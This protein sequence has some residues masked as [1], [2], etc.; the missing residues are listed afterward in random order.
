MF[1]LDNYLQNNNWRIV[2]IQKIES[3][4]GQYYSYDD[5]SLSEYTKILLN[6]TVQKG[7]YKHQKEAI[8]R[9]LNGNNVCLSTGTASGKSLVFYVAGIEKLIEQHDTRILAIYPLKALGKEQE[10]RWI[11]ALN[12]AKINAHV[13]RLDGQ[14]PVNSRSTI[15]KDKSIL[16]S[17]PDI[18][19]AWLMPN[20][21]DRSVSTFLRNLSL[22]IVDEIH[23]YTGVFGSNSAYLFRRLQHVVNIFGS[24]PQYITASA[25]IANPELHLKNLLEKKFEIID[26]CLDTSPRHKVTIKLV[27]PLQEK[28][29]L[30]ALSELMKYIAKD[31]NYRFIAFVD[32][33][34]QT[35][36]ITSIISRSQTQDDEESLNYDNLQKLD[37]LPYRSGYEETD[38][39]A[40]QER[41]ST[42]KLKGVVSTSALELGIDIPCLNLGI[43]V[44]VPRSSTSFYQR[45]GRIGRHSD[46]EIIVINTG[47]IYSESI[48]RNPDRLL[49]IPLAEGALYLQN[50]RVQYIHALCLARTGGEHDQVYASINMD[51]SKPFSSSIDWPDGFID[52]C[53]D[54]RKGIIPSELQNMKAQAGDDPNHAYPLRD[55]DIQFQVKNKEHGYENSCGS[56]SYNQLMRETYPGAVYYYITRPYRVYRVNTRS[57]IVEVRNE[58]RYTTKPQL[59][60]TLVFPNLTPGNIH[61]GQRYD[62]LVVIECNLQI[63][64]CI[65]GI[66]ERR[67]PSEISVNYPHTSEFYYDKLR[68]TRNYFTTG[69]TLTHP[70]FN[71]AGVRLDVISNLLFEAFLMTIPFERR[72]INFGND[73]HRMDYQTINEGQ[74][75]VCIYDQTYESLR[76]SGRII[77]KQILRQVFD[78]SIELAMNNDSLDI[79]NETM[80]TLEQLSESLYNSPIDLTPEIEDK[81]QLNIDNSERIIMPDSKG[82]NIEK[83]N[84]E[85]LVEGIFFS[86]LYK[87]LA[88]RGNYTLNVGP[89]YKDSMEIIPI[90]ALKSIPGESKMGLYNYETGEIKEL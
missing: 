10:E 50:S 16:I 57:R 12:N 37:I 45:I 58:K 44:G 13:G 66:K 40:I 19:H 73:K 83:D 28:D 63:R 2:N 25:T 47:D 82:L 70:R 87:S 53:M 69:V 11:E 1:N 89:R 15:F 5:L 7:L 77:E 29:L 90:K 33:R 42:G 54:E 32:S 74:R 9:F 35:E 22:I 46:G 65:I 41:L 4:E 48:F 62:D 78:G 80:S 17:T 43:L 84:E 68:F 86:P 79:D 72:D 56:L 81:L 26:T 38:R 21:G 18:I 59:I 61:F 24:S 88:Y 3:R 23:N 60:P 76:L 52:L 51:D 20:L 39:N 6:K 34:K 71:T 67:G 49:N 31:T 64:D 8:S 85:F 14:V 36:Y 27:N 30:N 75:F 55:I